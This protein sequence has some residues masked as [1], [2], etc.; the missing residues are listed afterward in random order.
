MKLISQYISEKLHLDKN[1]EIEDENNLSEEELNYKFKLLIVGFGDTPKE[2]IAD[3]EKN[4]NKSPEESAKK[5]KKLVKLDKFLVNNHFKRKDKASIK[6]FNINDIYFI[7]TDVNRYGNCIVYDP[8]MSI[9]GKD[10]GE[11]YV[12]LVGKCKNQMGKTI[13]PIECIEPE[14]FAEENHKFYSEN[15]NQT[16]FDDIED[17]WTY[18]TKKYGTF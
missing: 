17:A 8:F 14:K 9:N 12:F 4:Y 10:E 11:N 2:I 15:I 13:N 3:N 7:K 5:L 16:Y 18:I 6:L 1:I